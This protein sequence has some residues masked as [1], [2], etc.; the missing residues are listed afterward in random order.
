MA[1]TSV[2]VDRYGSSRVCFLNYFISRFVRSADHN[3]AP[4]DNYDYCHC[5]VTT[6][7]CLAPYKRNCRASTRGNLYLESYL[8]S[9]APAHYPPL[10]DATLLLFLS[11]SH[12][13]ALFR[14]LPFFFLLTISRSVSPPSV[15]SHLSLSFPLLSPCFCFS[16]LPLSLTLYLFVFSFSTSQCFAMLSLYFCSLCIYIFSSFS[17]PHPIFRYNSHFFFRL[18]LLLLHF[19]F[20]FLFSPFSL[21][22]FYLFVIR[23]DHTL[24]APFVQHFPFLFFPH[25]LL[26][27]FKTRR[28]FLK[29]SI[30]VLSCSLLPF[31]NRSQ[32][33][34]L[35]STAFS[36]CSL[37]YSL[38]HPRWSPTN[39][40]CNL[41]SCFMPE[42]LPLHFTHSL[43]PNVFSTLTPLARSCTL[44]KIRP[45]GIE[46]NFLFSSVL[47]IVFKLFF[48][49]KRLS[50]K[51]M[52]HFS[53]SINLF[54]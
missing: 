42:H 36:L 17:V 10:F 16:P 49:V 51:I 25:W 54:L 8:P 27:H 15:I 13:L 19:V 48:L 50:P 45:F 6:A 3:Y 33:R 7:H 12:S 5:H 11:Y 28:P 35:A 32:V 43:H 2:S 18:L 38:S 20:V 4:W 31:V 39:P 9:I 40:E 37:R 47:I 44:E 24:H 22:S 30:L 52:S 41:H 1:K 29:Q 21:C 14:S 23:L 53:I 46:G 26:N 34:P